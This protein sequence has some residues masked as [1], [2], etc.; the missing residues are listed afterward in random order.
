MPIKNPQELFV[1]LL[2]DIRQH[3]ERMTIICQ[4][5]SQVA[6][7]S[8]IKESLNS[9]VF[10]GDKIINTL[11]QCFK[12]LGQQPMKTSDRLQDVFVEDFRKELKEIQS[13]MAKAL[14][15]AAKANHL[16][17]FR[18]GEYVSLIAMADISG[19]YGLGMLLESC[20]ADKLSFVDR[21]RRRIE[22]LVESEAA[23]G[24]A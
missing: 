2:S 10:L 6:E 12:V 24:V 8:E 15:V 18:I 21:T 23:A 4:E 13:P 22:H 20:L 14:Y 17:Q 11:D 19:H 1:K 5:L 16:M 9:R 7:D 3:E